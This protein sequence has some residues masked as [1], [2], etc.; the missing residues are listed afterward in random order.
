MSVTETCD[1][2]G[3]PVPPFTGQITSED[4]VCGGCIWKVKLAQL[5]YLRYCETVERSAEDGA[6]PLLLILRRQI[7][8][9]E[10]EVAGD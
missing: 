3:Q 7:A 6:S 5:E 9:L 4:V 2:C 1:V 8:Q 10:R